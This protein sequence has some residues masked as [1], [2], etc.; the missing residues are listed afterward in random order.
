MKLTKQNLR[1][2][3][4]MM[5]VVL[6]LSALAMAAVGGTGDVSDLLSSDQTTK[7]DGIRGDLETRLPPLQR[8]LEAARMELETVMASASPDLRRARTLR[9][10]IR[11]LEVAMDDAWMK[12]ADRTSRL[13]T[14]DQRARIGDPRQ[15]LMGSGTWYDGWYCPWDRAVG[16]SW[17]RGRFSRGW[18]RSSWG[19]TWGS[20][21]R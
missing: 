4:G 1:T 3:I 21:C 9:Q 19:N 12:A 13:L 6:T 10:K 11:D 15:L 17:M 18:D 14:P 20:C 5:V 7:L 8:E 2:S 16:S